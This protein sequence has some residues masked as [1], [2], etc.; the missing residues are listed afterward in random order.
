MSENIIKINETALDIASN[1]YAVQ[2]LIYYAISNYDVG[3]NEFSTHY[4]G[5]AEQ[6]NVDYSTSFIEKLKALAKFYGDTAHLL[7]EKYETF[8]EVDNKLSNT[9]S[10]TY[11]NAGK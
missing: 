5:K 9:L 4:L 11:L 3:Y 10:N 6:L 8:E 7:E 2:E 1:L